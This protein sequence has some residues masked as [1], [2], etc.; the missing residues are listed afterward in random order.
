MA[1][2]LIYLVDTYTKAMDGHEPECLDDTRFAARLSEGYEQ[3]STLPSKKV[4]IGSKSVQVTP[5]VL[6]IKGDR[7]ALSVSDNRGPDVEFH[8]V[9]GTSSRILTTFTSM[10]DKLTKSVSTALAR[11]SDDASHLGKL[12][13]HSMPGLSIISGELVSKA[14][15]AGAIAK[16]S[17]QPLSACPFPKGSAPATKWHQGWHAAS[18]VPPTDSAALDRIRADACALAQSLSGDDEV[19]VQCPFRPG[20]DTHHAWVE[21]FKKGGGKVE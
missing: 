1:D 15:D 18:K 7:N 6:R 19:E 13:D 10:V 8:E 12:R 16:D 14:Y 4:K 20:T 11:T 2:K 21:G 17:G 3:L 5:M 9:E